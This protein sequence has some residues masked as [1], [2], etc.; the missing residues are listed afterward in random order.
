[1]LYDKSK[2]L[3]VAADMRKILIKNKGFINHVVMIDSE[4]NISIAEI[5]ADPGR[6]T[7]EIVSKI[8]AKNKDTLYAVIVVDTWVVI[9]TP[10]ELAT[11][12]TPPSQRQG[13]REALIIQARSIDGS[14]GFSVIDTYHREGDEIV[15]DGDPLHSEI[16]DGL[17]VMVG[18]VDDFFTGALSILLAEE[19]L[20]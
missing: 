5:S 7:S 9:R 19:L 20:S 14:E 8:G 13:K 17:T 16:G 3:G 12:G 10:E 1:M 4:A 11:D 2:A 15:F 18:L 6:P